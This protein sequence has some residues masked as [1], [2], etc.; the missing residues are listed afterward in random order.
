MDAIA[1]RTLFVA[2]ALLAA[3]PAGAESSVENCTLPA[4]DAD[5]LADRAGILAQYE[6]LPPACLRALFHECTRASGE[7]LL[8]FG[9][10]AVCSFGYEALLSQAFGGNFRAL[11]AWW[12]AQREEAVQ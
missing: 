11:M 8:D 12:R 6:R 9:T 2:A 7:Q 5:P 3:A 1:V 4:S 10:A